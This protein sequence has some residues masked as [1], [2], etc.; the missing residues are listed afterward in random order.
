MRRG[1]GVGWVGLDACWADGSEVT[2]KEDCEMMVAEY[3]ALSIN[4][5]RSC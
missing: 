5:D 4:V 1:A 2:G 3:S